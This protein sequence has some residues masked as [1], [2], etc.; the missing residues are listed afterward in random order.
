MIH[1]IFDFDFRKNEKMKWQKWQTG[2]Q[3]FVARVF[4]LFHWS[5][6]KVAELPRILNLSSVMGLFLLCAFPATST[7]LLFF[8]YLEIVFKHGSMAE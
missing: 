8:P 1:L 3:R 6:R 7:L 5:K 4:L 2:W